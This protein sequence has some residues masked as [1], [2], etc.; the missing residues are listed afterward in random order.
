[1][2][3]KITILCL[4]TP[5]QFKI[6]FKHFFSNFAE[7]LL[8]KL[9]KP[10]DK[11]PNAYKRLKQLD[12]QRELNSSLDSIFLSEY[13]LIILNVGSTILENFLWGTARFYFRS[14]FVFDLRERYATCS[15][16]KFTFICK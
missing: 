3:L 10:P 11:P 5:V 15:K 1:M 7:S 6:F 8:I 9:P 13:F 16:I 2:R 14:P 12:S 4:M